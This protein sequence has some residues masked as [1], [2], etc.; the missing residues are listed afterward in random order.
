MKWEKVKDMY[1]N[2]EAVFVD[3]RDRWDFNEGHIPG[4]LNIEEYNFEEYLPEVL[5]FAK[6]KNY[7]VYCDGDDCDTSE[8]LAFKLV[9]LGFTR[10]YVYEEGWKNWTSKGFDIEKS[11]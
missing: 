11:E 6:N 7:I 5:K 2:S 3:A 4:A 8:R 9:E 1:N 10:V